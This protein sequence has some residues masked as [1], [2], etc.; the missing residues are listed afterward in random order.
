[1]QAGVVAQARHAGRDL[2]QRIGVAIDRDHQRAAG[3]R[4]VTVLGRVVEGLRQRLAVIE[5][6]DRRQGVVQRVGVRAVGLDHQGAVGAIDGRARCGHRRAIQR[7]HRQAAVLGRRVRARARQHAARRRARHAVFRHRVGVRRS[8]RSGVRDRH[9]QRVRTRLAVGVRDG[10]AKVVMQVRAARVRQHLGGVAVADLARGFIKAAQHQFTLV[11]ADL[12]GRAG[13]ALELGQRQADSGRTS[14]HR[15]AINARSRFQF[16]LRTGRGTAFLNGV[17]VPQHMR[18]HHLGL[19]VRVAVDRDHQ[20]GSAEAAILVSH[21]VAELF[22]KRLSVIQLV[23]GRIR[24]VQFVGIAAVRLQFQDAIL[25]LDRARAGHDVECIAVLAEL[26]VGQHVARGGADPIFAHRMA[27]G[28]GLRCRVRDLH[29]QAILA[30]HPR[31]VF[32][33]HGDQ[34]V[35]RR[36]SDMVKRLRRV[37]ITDRARRRIEARQGQCAFVGRQGQGG[38]RAKRL[39]LCQSQRQRSRAIGQ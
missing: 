17:I 38:G 23:D 10:Q 7:G 8:H 39:Q 14:G 37:G 35:Q 21:R 1:M 33:R 19:A 24:V 3:G 11:G 22:F 5:L 32:D 36:A 6:V 16:E 28:L 34:V 26:V 25:A 4:A 12:L 13:Q 2:G 27:V 18:R 15:Q 29:Q 9:A 31:R 20:V 30:R